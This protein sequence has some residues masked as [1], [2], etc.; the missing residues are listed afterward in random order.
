MPLVCQSM[1][2]NVNNFARGIPERAGK[3]KSMPWE[4]NLARKI[5][6]K[7]EKGIPKRVSKRKKYAPEIETG[8]KRAY[9]RER[10]KEKVCPEKR[11]WQEK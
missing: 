9:Q 3:R 4:A 8:K 6:K 11:I 7:L 2:I 10:A 5:S 1:S